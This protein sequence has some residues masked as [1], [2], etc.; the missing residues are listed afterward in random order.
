VPSTAIV[1]HPGSYTLAHP[2][3]ATKAP[4]IGYTISKRINCWGLTS[5]PTAS[6]SPTQGA[7]AQR[8]TAEVRQQCH[9]C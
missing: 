1:A 2:R 6:L 5:M 9:C 4:Q 3:P 8:L 7:E